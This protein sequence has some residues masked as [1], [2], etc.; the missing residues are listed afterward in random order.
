MERG[1]CKT[2][3]LWSLEPNWVTDFSFEYFKI[4]YKIILKIEKFQKYVTQI[5]TKNVYIS[6]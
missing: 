2:K 6:T 3:Q 1:S 5:T 4:V